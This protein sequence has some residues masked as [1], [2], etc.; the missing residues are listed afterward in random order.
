MVHYMLVL[1]LGVKLVRPTGNQVQVSSNTA[2]ANEYDGKRMRR[3]IQ[4]RT[5]DYNAST[6]QMVK[7]SITTTFYSSQHI[8]WSNITQ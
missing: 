7:V 6:I 1:Y 2:T 5:V 8:F 4:R 3:S